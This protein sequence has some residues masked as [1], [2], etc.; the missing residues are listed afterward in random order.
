MVYQSRSKCF[1]EKWDFFCL[2]VN[3]EKVATY[4]HLLFI[5]HGQLIFCPKVVFIKGCTISVVP[6]CC[7]VSSL[8]LLFALLRSL[9]TR[10]ASSLPS[11]L[12]LSLS[13]YL[14][15]LGVS[16]GLVA[17]MSSL[18]ELLNLSLEDKHIIAEYIWYGFFFLFL[19]GVGCLFVFQCALFRLRC[20]LRDFFWGG[21]FYVD[22]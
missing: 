6:G 3:K 8:R 7:L 19:F 18:D 10:R 16:F 20:R 4:Y 9:R 21:L 22:K 14:H 11:S 13:L 5:F 1:L 15:N 12:S 2:E 17:A